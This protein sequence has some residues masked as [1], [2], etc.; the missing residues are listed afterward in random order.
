MYFALPIPFEQYILFF[1]LFLFLDVQADC[2]DADIRTI[3]PTISFKTHIGSIGAVFGET[4]AHS[5]QTCCGGA[6][7]L[8][9]GAIVFHNQADQPGFSPDG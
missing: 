2:P 8:H 6:A 7:S 3:N 9:R 4:E 1:F 5:D